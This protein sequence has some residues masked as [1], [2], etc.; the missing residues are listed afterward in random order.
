MADK[1]KVMQLQA[2]AT[3]KT[4]VNKDKEVK[5]FLRVTINLNGIDCEFK[6]ADNTTRELLGIVFENA[7]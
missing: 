5:E 4:Y 1:D 3:S 2:K 7:K 6:P